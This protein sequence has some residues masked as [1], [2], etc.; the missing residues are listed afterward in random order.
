MS[1]NTPLDGM[2][3]C[4]E[5]AV[6]GRD[7]FDVSGKTGEARWEFHPQARSGDNDRWA[8]EEPSRGIPRC[9]PLRRGR[10]LQQDLMA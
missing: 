3:A 7:A 6:W 1:A 10:G 2:K 8:H 4:A 5:R 9:I